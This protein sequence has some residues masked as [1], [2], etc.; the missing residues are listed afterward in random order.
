MTLVLDASALVEFVL[1]SGKGRQVLALVN[2][3]GAD[4]H[5]PELIVAESLSALRSLQRRSEIAPGR[6]TEAAADLRSVSLVGY[7]TRTLADRIW[8]L[9]GRFTMY[10]A[11]YVALADVLGAPLITGDRRL[12]NAAKDLIPVH[13]V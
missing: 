8:A 7:P 3:S 5:A 4:L 2:L 10:D 11:H 12:A 13:I 1:G 6:A 9:R